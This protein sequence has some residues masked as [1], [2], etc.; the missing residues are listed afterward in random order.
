[1]WK[2]LEVLNRTDHISHR[3]YILVTEDRHKEKYLSSIRRSGLLGDF[4]CIIYKGQIPVVR[5]RKQGKLAAGRTGI[6]EDGLEST[7]ISPKDLTWRR[8]VIGMR[9]TWSL[10]QTQESLKLKE[11]LAAVEEGPGLVVAPT[12]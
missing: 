6:H 7:L 8:E 1:M 4:I 3:A 11:D 12:Q 9:R 10:S 2:L 5:C